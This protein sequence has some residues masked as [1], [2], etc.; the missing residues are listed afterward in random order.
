MLVFLACALVCLTFTDFLSLSHT[1]TQWQGGQIW[2]NRLWHRKKNWRR[3]KEKK[4]LKIFV[5]ASQ[6]NK[7]NMK[8]KE[9]SS[10]YESDLLSCSSLLR[11]VAVDAQWMLRHIHKESFMPHVLQNES[12]TLSVLLSSICTPCYAIFSLIELFNRWFH[13]GWISSGVSSCS[14]GSKRKFTPISL[15]KRNS[16]L[17]SDSFKGSLSLSL[18]LTQYSQDTCIFY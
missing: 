11:P 2:Q 10:F 17:V 5:S 6:R 15:Y 13:S 14:S 4:S 9:S 16:L 8:V 3:E 7:A 1:H 12:L 18:F